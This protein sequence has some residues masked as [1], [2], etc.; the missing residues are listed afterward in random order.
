MQEEGV[1]T[2]EKIIA[3]LKIVKKI[4][5]NRIANTACLPEDHEIMVL[6][7]DIEVLHKNIMV[8]K[9]QDKTTGKEFI[10]KVLINFCEEEMKKSSKGQKTFLEEHL[11]EKCTLQTHWLLYEDFL[12]NSFETISGGFTFTAHYDILTEKWAVY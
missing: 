2:K 4:L 6:L 12:E 7:R 9:T 3:S 5:D 11:Q 10:K 1:M 8:G